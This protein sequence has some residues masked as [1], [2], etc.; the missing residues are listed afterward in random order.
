MIIK[1]K[2]K[3]YDKIVIVAHP[4]DE[5]IFYGSKLIKDD[6]NKV[7]CLTNA[8]T[9]RF[10][11]FKG[12]M[13]YVKC[14]YV[15]MDHKDDS[16]IKY[17]KPEYKEY[18]YNFLKANHP[19]MKRITTHNVIGEYGHNFHKAISEMVY[20]I[21][22]ELNILHKLYYFSFGKRRLNETLVKM[23]YALMEMY[24]PSQFKVLHKLK[25]KEFIENET[26]IQHYK[27][28]QRK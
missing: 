17:I 24:Y 22:K 19:K 4:D 2:N 10:N 12:L 26:S 5:L 21:C 27:N 20:E 9:K 16:R 23:K 3:L 18:I 28:F 7:I 8:T 13:Q 6:M 25:I 14:G 1:E 15:I 11:E